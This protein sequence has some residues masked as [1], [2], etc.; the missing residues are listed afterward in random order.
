MA[1][2]ARPSGTVSAG[3][4]SPIGGPST[5]WECMD[6]VTANDSTDYI[7]AINGDNTTCEIN[8]SSVT[9]P[10]GNVNHT[11]RFRMQGTGSGG[12]E[13]LTVQLF[14]GATLIRELTNQTSRA[15]W[16]SKEFTLT[17][18]EADNIGVYTDLRLK[19]ISSNLAATEDMWCTWAEFEVPDA[20]EGAPD[21][22]HPEYPDQHMDTV[23][24]IPYGNMPGSVDKG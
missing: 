16:G 11:V 15:A 10:V 12:P 22:P 6:E 3:L 7:E 13:R 17:T 14:D 20:S 9:D 5:L 24:L 2:F 23:K 21:I 19:F 4:W 1:Q 18:T 8:L